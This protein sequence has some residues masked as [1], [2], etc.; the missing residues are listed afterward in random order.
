MDQPVSDDGVSAHD[1][2]ADAASV[3]STMNAVAS[4]VTVLTWVPYIGVLV[5]TL[6]RRKRFSSAE[7]GI[8][9]MYGVGALGLLTG[10]VGVFA[11][12]SWLAAVLTIGFG[13]VVVR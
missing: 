5:Y 3:R 12:S 4:C 10:I 13:G 9:A 2:A 6:C 11:T 1:C 7:F 8:R